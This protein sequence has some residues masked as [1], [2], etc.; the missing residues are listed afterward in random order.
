MKHLENDPRMFCEL[1]WLW[2][3]WLRSGRPAGCST[4][5]RAR[6]MQPCLAPLAS[7]LVGAAVFANA[8]LYATSAAELP[9]RVLLSLLAVYGFWFMLALWRRRDWKDVCA[10]DLAFMLA[11]PSYRDWLAATPA[12]QRVRAEVGPLWDDPS[13]S[14]CYTPELETV[15]RPTMRDALRE[16]LGA[17]V[18]GRFKPGRYFAHLREGKRSVSRC[19]QA[20]P[21]ERLALE[22]LLGEMLPD[23]AGE[24][25]V[26]DMLSG[27]LPRGL[28]EV[29]VWARDPWVDLTRA[30]D[31][32][33][34]ASLPP[35][36]LRAA[37]ERRT[38]GMLGPFGYLRNPSISALDFRTAEGRCVRARLAAAR[39]GQALV[40]FVD[41]VE[42][43]YD[44]RPR[45]VARAVEDYAR[46]AGFDAVAYHAHPLNKVPRR[47]VRSLNGPAVGVR[48]AFL[49]CAEREYLD[50]F[51]WPL[52]PFEYARPVG[53][54]SAH[55]VPLTG[56]AVDRVADWRFPKENVLPLLVASTA[57]CLAWVLAR[58]APAA[59][60]PTALAFGLA[61]ILD[62]R[63]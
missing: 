54:V 5:R 55:V 12:A 23:S 6:H 39:S 42:G 37:L 33:S 61:L 2:R 32:Y 51:G 60:P 17:K 1:R 21:D 44:V 31:F 59:L 25:Y 47:F 48:L 15:E 8:G 35:D 57:L 58:T 20:L 28:V 38:K 16:V 13:Y 14:V 22:T 41:A 56:V 24:R 45:L 11:E 43:R 10:D 18:D 26:R 27:E 9:A 46:A 29:S 40:L 36:T 53:T 50:A 63:R 4:A 34:S 3:R 49:E 19:V 52:E 62:R 30:S 7:L